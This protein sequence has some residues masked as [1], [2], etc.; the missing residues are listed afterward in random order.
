MVP[1]IKKENLLKSKRQKDIPFG[2]LKGEKSKAK[3]VTAPQNPFIAL[4]IKAGLSRLVL[5]ACARALPAALL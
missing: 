1:S 3:V 2:S 4:R 5:L